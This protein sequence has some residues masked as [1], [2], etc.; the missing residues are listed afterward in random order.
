MLP[1]QRPDLPHAQV[2]LPLP[3]VQPHH[4]GAHAALVAPPDGVLGHVALGEVDGT[5]AAVGRADV[6]GGHTPREDLAVVV[7]LLE[8][9]LEA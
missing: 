7:G 1:A 9:E 2:L 3:R 8:G 6:T 5:Q 4:D